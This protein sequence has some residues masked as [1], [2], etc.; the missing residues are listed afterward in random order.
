[1]SEFLAM[2]GYARY[3]WPSIGLFVGLL[4]WMALS[5]RSHHRRA[6]ARLRSVERGA[7]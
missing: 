2:G 5:A 1:M 7:A 4:L 6:L 3:V